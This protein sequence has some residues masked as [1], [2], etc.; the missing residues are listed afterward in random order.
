MHTLKFKSQLTFVSFAAINHLNRN[1]RKQKITSTSSKG[2][3]LRFVIGEF[4]Y[5][6]W[7]CCLLLVIV[8]I[9]ASAKNTIITSSLLKFRIQVLLKSAVRFKPSSGL[10]FLPK[11]PDQSLVSKWFQ[12][13]W[14]HLLFQFWI[15]EVGYNPGRG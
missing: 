11:L 10:N 12:G 2:H 4:L 8:I 9:I 13:K 1:L 6:L 5:I 7:F 3:G 15:K 14:S